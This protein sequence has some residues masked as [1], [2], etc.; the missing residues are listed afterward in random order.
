MAPPDHH[1]HDHHGHEHA[2]EHGSGHGAA[3][4]DDHHHHGADASERRLVTALSVL[5][6]FTL[7]RL[8][9]A[10]SPTRSRCSPRRR[11]C[12]LIRPHSCSRSLPFTPL[13][14]RRVRDAPT[15]TAV[16][17]PSLPS[18]TVNCCCC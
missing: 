3:H 15:V 7:S 18:S 6:I 2:H 11:T 12:W 13:A 14:A 5:G 8:P 16:T 1:S 4:G 9:A 10:T 17:S